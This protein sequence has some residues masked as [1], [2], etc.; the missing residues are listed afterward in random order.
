MNK[1]LVKAE[2]IVNENKISVLRVRDTDY[3]SLT[4]LAKYANPTEP[5]FTIK[6]WIRRADTVNFIGLWEK[7]HNPSFNL[8]EFAQIKTE[9]GVN[10]F[11]MSPTQWVRR[12]GANSTPS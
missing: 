11:Y 2:I 4:D 12:T 9:Y 8:A 7:L 1:S 5:S 6:D 3:I 10:K